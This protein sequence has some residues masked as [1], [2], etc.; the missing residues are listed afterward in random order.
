MQTLHSQIEAEPFPAVRTMERNLEELHNAVSQYRPLLYRRAY[1]YLGNACD[2]EDAVQEALLSAF[3]HLDQFKGNAKMMTWLT[4][5]V[6]NSALT[7]LRRRPRQPHSSLDERLTKE[8]NLRVSDTLVDIRPNPEDYCAISETHGQ[9][10]KDIGQLSPMLRE[11]IQLRDF[12]ELTTNEAA[13]IL[14]VPEST[15]KTRVSRA[16]ARL[17]LHTKLEP[18]HYSSRESYRSYAPRAGR[19]LE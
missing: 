6:T 11:A 9:L 5:I 14:G 7:Q 19:Q 1:R 12:D 15:L 17:A 2:A 18:K 10:M 4:S 3:K 8:Q 16:R 13:H